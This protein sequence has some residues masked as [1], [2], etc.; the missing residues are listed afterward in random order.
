M[1]NKSD[2]NNGKREKADKIDWFGIHLVIAE[3]T[4]HSN[5][6]LRPIT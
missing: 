3:R 5:G 4:K 6:L 2:N 1:W